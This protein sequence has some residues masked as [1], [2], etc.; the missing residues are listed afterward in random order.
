VSVNH[1]VLRI[2]PKI[3]LMISVRWTRDF[4]RMELHA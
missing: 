4:S 2:A 3:P 1:A